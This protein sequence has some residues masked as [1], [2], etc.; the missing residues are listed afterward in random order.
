[1]IQALRHYKW[2]KI[3]EKSGLFDVKYYLFTYPDVRTQDIDPITHYVKYG[4][5]EG[6]NPS[7]EFNTSFYFRMYTDV[8]Q[9]K[10]NPFV[11]YVLHGSKENRKISNKLIVKG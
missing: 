4:A 2:K 8:F 7:A 5:A 10:I 9:S 3:I 1:M 6:K 11:H